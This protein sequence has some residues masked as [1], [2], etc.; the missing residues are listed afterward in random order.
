[1]RD[2]EAIEETPDPFY[3]L[4]IGLLTI[5]ESV[6]PDSF[7]EKRINEEREALQ[8]VR[9]LVRTVLSRYRVRITKTY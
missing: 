3:Q 2:G 6:H 4:R 5:V 1:V 7:K 9:G 8:K